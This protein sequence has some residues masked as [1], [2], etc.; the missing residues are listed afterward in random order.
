M[1]KTIALILLLFCFIGSASSQTNY[2]KLIEKNKFAR[3][4]KKLNKRLSRT[5]DNIVLNYS[6]AVLLSTRA[7]KKYNCYLAYS[8]AMKVDKLFAATQD[9]KA[10]SECQ[11]ANISMLSISNL[12]DTICVRAKDDA[13]ATNNLDSLDK[14]LVFFKRAPKFCRDQVTAKRDEVA[15]DIACTGNTVECF[16]KFIATYPNS[17]QIGTAIAE[18]DELAFRKAV[19]A[20]TIP[21]YKEFIGAYP[22]A[23]QVSSAWEHIHELAM[24]QARLKNTSDAYRE[25]MEEYPQSIQYAEAFKLYEE[26]LFYEKTIVGN[27]ISYRNFIWYYADNSWVA[28]A[29]DSIFQIGI[30]NDD[31]LALQYCADNFEGPDK[32][33]AICCYH[34]VYTLDGELKTLDE[35][36][37]SYYLDTLYQQRAIDYQLAYLGDSLELYLPYDYAKKG[38]YDRYIKTAAPRDR[39]FVALQRMISPY[40]KAK[41]WQNAIKIA[42]VYKPY[43]GRRSKQV[44]DL[45]TLLDRSLDKSIQVN[46]VGNLVNTAYAREYSPIISADDRSLYFCGKERKDNVGGEDI[47]VS[48]RTPSGWANPKVVD[49]LSDQENNAPVGISADGNEMLLFDNGDIY[50]SVKEPYGWSPSSHLNNGVNTEYWEGDATMTSDGNHMIFVRSKQAFVAKYDIVFL[51]DATGS[52]Q[53]CIDGVK[54]NIMSFISNLS[55]DNTREVDWRAKIISYRD[56]NQDLNAYDAN[57]FTS[58]ENELESQL[59]YVRADGGGD[60]PEST[61]ESLHRSILETEWRSE[62]DV[63]KVIVCFTDATNNDRVSASYK[64]KHGSVNATSIVNELNKRPSLSLFLFGQIDNDYSIIDGA[65]NANVTQYVDAVS[66]LQNADYSLMMKSLSDKISLLANNVPIYH[67]DQQ[68]NGDIYV[69]SRN[70]DGT[71]EEALSLGSTINTRYSERS[72]FLHPDMKTLYFS[73]DGHGGL[74]KLDVYMSTRLYDT[75][76]DCWSEPVNLGKEINTAE[77]DWGYKISTD[78]E[79]GYFAKKASGKKNEDIFYVDIPPYLRPGFVATVSGKLLTKSNQPVAADMRWENL[80]TGEE[81][82]KAKSDPADGSYF[83]VLPMGINYGYYVDKENYFP[84]SNNIDLRDSVK[85][86]TIEENIQILTFKEMLDD[87]IAVPIQNLFFDFGK[88]EIM[89]SSLPELKRVA[90]IIRSNNLKVQIIGHTDNVGDDAANQVL[91]EKR[92]QAVKDFLVEEGCNSN[93]LFTIGFGESRPITSND[94]EQGRAKNRRVELI[95]IK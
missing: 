40:V 81:M 56:V 68:L 71:W 63:A 80:E 93:F 44:D 55:M 27:W 51:I 69:A 94:N 18:R 31:V 83:I 20:N 32:V 66:E 8:V 4:E 57:D 15:F 85:A 45:I 90:K 11:K 86:V 28:A 95:F 47:Y 78:G 2:I 21:A 58:S 1:K 5:P 82:G 74:G 10:Q 79:K 50:S 92:A 73:S 53:P 37:A 29:R 42:E 7:Y 43:F 6:K 76:W 30:R 24:N 41:D 88:S 19:D 91:S 59:S 87:S 33:R 75:C 35:F 46:S 17:L 39:A 14:Y 60:E 84:A 25:F 36:Y 34:D 70:E 13:I 26:R 22:K 48:T 9:R 77:S 72:P 38:M 64:R 62:E 3:A 49:E 65:K 12:I 54:D 67:G 89:K 52:M 23:Y 61:I 16:E